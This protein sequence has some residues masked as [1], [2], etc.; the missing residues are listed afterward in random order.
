[1]DDRGTML[2]RL[3][4]LKREARALEEALG[5]APACEPPLM[6]DDVTPAVLAL[7]AEYALDLIS[8]HAANGDYVFAS[9]NAARTLGWSP[10]ELVGRNAYEFF[11]P[12]DAGRVAA[13]H[14]AHLER[15][16]E[17]AGIRYRFRT[18]GGGW[19]WVESRSRASEDGRWI[20]AITRDVQREQEALEALERFALTD[21]VTGLPNRRALEDALAR[22]LVRGRRC[23][24]PLSVVFFDLDGFKA[25]NDSRG[26]DEGDRILGRVARCLE[27]ARR[28]Y[29][30]AGR[31]GG[32]EFLVV[33]PDTADADAYGVA[34]RIRAA[35]AAEEP[36]VTL[37]MGV[38]VAVPGL[39]GPDLMARADAALY[40]V[41]RRGGD[42]IDVWAGEG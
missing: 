4:A 5:L 23:S 18:R 17:P 21:P 16:A 34:A 8:V 32:D 33:L 28:G 35:V 29:D 31:W 20:V 24:R 27:R 11:H 12:D 13:D 1:V 38:A 26:H 14:A 3:G 9:P 22:E 19:R 39:P 15:A 25:V 7:V 41:K 30:V 6:P 2:H 10:A 42:G 37:S 36:R 40:R